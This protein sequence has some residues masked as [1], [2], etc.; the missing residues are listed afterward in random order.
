MAQIVVFKCVTSCRT[1]AFSLWLWSLSHSAYI[2]T[3]AWIHAWVH[4]ECI[5]KQKIR[6]EIGK[7]ENWWK[8][9]ENTI[10]LVIIS[11]KFMIFSGKKITKSLFAEFLVDYWRW[12]SVAAPNLIPFDLKAMIRLL[13]RI[14]LNNTFQCLMLNFHTLDFISLHGSLCFHCE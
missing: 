2:F 12:F 13:A 11:E 3:F 1:L 4:V 8:F 5:Q 7:F 6:N 10:C 9:L 14:Y